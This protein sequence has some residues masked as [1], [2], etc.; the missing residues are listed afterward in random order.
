MSDKQASLAGKY[1]QERQANAV[2]KMQLA[3]E[4]ATLTRIRNER[5]RYKRLYRRYMPAFYTSVSC[6]IAC[7]AGGAGYYASSRDSEPQYVAATVSEPT[8]AQQAYAS[9]PDGPVQVSDVS[10]GYVLGSIHLAN[11]DT[12][13]SGTVISQGVEYAA[14]VS[15]AHCFRGVIG[16]H[17]TAFNPDGSSMEATLLAMDEKNDI[18]LFR[19]PAD[20]ILGRSWVPDDGCIP[21]VG[22]YSA[23]GYTHTT[24][25]IYKACQLADR[26]K[27]R[28]EGGGEVWMYR[29]LYEQSPPK[30][31]FGGGDSG[32]GIFKNGALLTVIST[33][34]KNSAAWDNREMR[35][36]GHGELAAFLRRNR[37][38]LRGCGPH[39]CP[40]NPDPRQE[41]HYRQQPPDWKPSPNIPIRPPTDPATPVPDPKNDVPPPP[42]YPP[43]KPDAPPPPAEDARVDRVIQQVSQLALEVTQMQAVVNHINSIAPRDGQD[44]PPGPQGPKGDKG[45]RGEPGVG[46]PGPAGLQGPP[47]EPGSPGAGIKSAVVNA[48]RHLILMLT[49][50][51]TIDAGPIMV[52]S[53]DAVD[54][55]PLVKRLD[56]IEQT[57]IS[58]RTLNADG[59]VYDSDEVNIWKGEPIEIGTSQLKDLSGI[60]E[61]LKGIETPIRV[62]H[63]KTGALIGED[64]VKLLNGDAIDLTFDPAALV[65]ASK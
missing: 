60:V 7:L 34:E 37:D 38:N 52:T 3:S 57:L 56:A 26:G 48:E 54:L 2:L 59:S 31:G 14:A 5:T 44:G 58:V 29:V 27:W 50:G 61:K 40:P 65:G 43:Q 39:G 1:V 25:P 45:D 35:G 22:V 17:F 63:D 18:A 11:G 13:C 15:A 51:E 55:S 19:L 16:G 30:T 24:G 36:C 6:W 49:S 47:G 8:A 42:G 4:S 32:G 41:Q 20:K 23:V 10:P 53:G 33:C 62:W 12:R 46:T 28:S 21:D 64:K 9:L